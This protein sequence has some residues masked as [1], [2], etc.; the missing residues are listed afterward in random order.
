MKIIKAK[1]VF[2]Y[3]QPGTTK[4]IENNLVGF[5]FSCNHKLLYPGLNK[6]EAI[7]EVC[8]VLK[9]KPRTFANIISYFD[10]LG[11]PY[12]MRKGF[13]PYRTWEGEKI[14][15]KYLDKVGGKYTENEAGLKKACSEARKILGIK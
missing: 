5:C 4:K 10:Y 3:K 11:N 13:E 8:K 14:M 9:I 2:T 7:A 1:P 12:N 15:D 6:T